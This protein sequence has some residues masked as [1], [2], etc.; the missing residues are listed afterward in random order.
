MEWCGAKEQGAKGAALR[1][2][3]A[4]LG[5][6]FVVV[7]VP[8]ALGCGAFPRLIRTALVTAGFS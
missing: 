8:G 5:M 4:L 7:A 2:C 1:Q 3:R 6:P